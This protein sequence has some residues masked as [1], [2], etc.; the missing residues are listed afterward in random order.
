MGNYADLKNH[1]AASPKTWLVTGIAGFIVRTGELDESG[2]AILSSPGCR[3]NIN[4]ANPSL[5]ETKAGCLELMLAQSQN[6][7][8]MKGA[9]PVLCH[10][11]MS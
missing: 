6:I 2:T 11:C 3:P 10:T 4:I 1:P 9:R 7:K 5:Y 8:G